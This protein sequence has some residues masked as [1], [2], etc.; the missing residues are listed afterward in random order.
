MPIRMYRFSPASLTPTY[1]IAA[2]LSWW[3]PT[4]IESGRQRLRSAFS[5]DIRRNREALNHQELIH[6]VNDGIEKAK[7]IVAQGR[8][9]V[10][11]L[12]HADR[13]H[14]ST[15]VLRAVLERRL[16]RTAVPL[17]WDPR[18]AASAITAGVG[19]RV[20]RFGWRAHIRMGRWSGDRRGH[21]DLC[22]L[23]TIP[24]NGPLFH[25]APCQ[26]RPDGRDRHG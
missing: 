4:P 23:E 13:M 11:L 6:S 22:R 12:E 17:V 20:Q 16:G 8:R 21:L 9:P 19:A 2:L 5:A 7:S 10:I 25:R 1:P 3:W 18:A 14:D 24:R 26:S 15:Y